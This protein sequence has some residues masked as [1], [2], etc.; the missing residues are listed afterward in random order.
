MS[1]L[2]EDVVAMAE[3]KALASAYEKKADWDYET[4]VYSALH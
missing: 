1:I 3:A 4:M 2:G